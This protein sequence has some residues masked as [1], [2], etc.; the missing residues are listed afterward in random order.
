MAKLT[1]RQLFTPAGSVDRATYA[2]FGVL[3]FAIKHN[4]DRFVAAY[5]FHQPWTLFNYWVPL[6]ET[7]ITQSEGGQFL[8]TPLPNGRTRLEGTTWYHHGLWPSAYWRLW[9]EAITHQIH[10]R[11]LKHIQAEAEANS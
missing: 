1:L 4:I 11:V 8:L 6:R 2:V 9:S 3:G 10:L 5:F 7:R